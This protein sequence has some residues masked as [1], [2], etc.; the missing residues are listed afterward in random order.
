MFETIIIGALPGAGLGVLAGLAMAIFCRDGIW[1]DLWAHFILIGF[2][3]G[4]VLGFL[5]YLIS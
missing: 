5:D 3:L 1:P 4:G 2:G